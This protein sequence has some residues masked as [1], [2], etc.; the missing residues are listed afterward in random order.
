MSVTYSLACPALGLTMWVGQGSPG[1]R[2]FYSGEPAVM[3]KLGRFLQ[4]ASGNALYLMS[5][6]AIDA[7]PRTEYEEFEGGHPELGLT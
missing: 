6:H 7:D 4:H 5:D 2:S 1:M 3:E